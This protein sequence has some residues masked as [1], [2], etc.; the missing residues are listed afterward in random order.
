MDGEWLTYRDLAVRLGVSVEAARRRALRGKWMRAPSN[1]GLTRVRPPD[2]LAP[3]MSVPD[4]KDIVPDTSALVTALEGHVETLK[5]QLAAAESRLGDA[6]VDLAT[7][8]ARTS[9]AISA[10]AAL[11]ERLDALATVRAT[12]WWR[13]LTG[14]A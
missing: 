6:A 7:E 14:T 12:P 10:F 11:A 8:R 9:A 13:R 4:A 1:D 5:A 2:G 3:L